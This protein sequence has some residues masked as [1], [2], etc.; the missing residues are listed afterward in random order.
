MVKLIG[1][2]GSYLKSIPE[3]AKEMSPEKAYVLRVICGDG[4]VSY[5]DKYVMLETISKEF[6]DEFRCC[7]TSVYG[8]S[9]GGKIKP[10]CNGKQRIVICG[11]EMT[12]DIRR[13]LPK[14]KSFEWRIPKSIKESSLKCRAA[15]AKGFFD[16]E[17]SVHKKY[18]LSLSSA[19][20]P[21]LHEIASLLL[22]LKIEPGN[23]TY[24]KNAHRLN[25][26]GR[27]NIIRFIS[28]VGTSIDSKR[29]KMDFLLGR[30]GV[31]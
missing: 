28:V 6:I 2:Q 30:Y 7:M 18:S 3:K 24:G 25:I 16:S 26:S 9:F 15:F 13:Y 29:K 10:T 27:E 8:E 14:Q 1:L 21:G 19:N 22:S 4:Y 23:I 31:L 5:K 20:L 11:R 12:E 17:G